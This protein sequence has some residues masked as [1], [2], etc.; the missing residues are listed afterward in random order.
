MLESYP[1][2]GSRRYS[3]YGEMAIIILRVENLTRALSLKVAD[4]SSTQT[5]EFTGPLDDS[6]EI[7]FHEMSELYLIGLRA[8]IKF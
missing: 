1:I 5:G 7:Y 2:V 6:L 8:S 4:S 3:C